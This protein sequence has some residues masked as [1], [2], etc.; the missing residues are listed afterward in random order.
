MGLYAGLNGVKLAFI[1]VRDGYRR[2][3]KIKTAADITF[4]IRGGFGST[5]SQGSAGIPPQCD[6]STA[7]TPSEPVTMVATKNVSLAAKIR[8]AAA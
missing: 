8:R 7:G 3:I 4:I 6:T 2:E 5:N 1:H